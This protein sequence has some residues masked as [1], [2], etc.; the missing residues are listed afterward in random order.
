MAPVQ[1]FGADEEVDRMRR[2]LALRE[3]GKVLVKGLLEN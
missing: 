3:K 2:E 1:V